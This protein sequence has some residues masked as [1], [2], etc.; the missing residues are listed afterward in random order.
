MG[1]VWVIVRIQ[2]RDAMSDRSILR[3]EHR[4]KQL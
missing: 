2:S 1:N 4:G 3:A